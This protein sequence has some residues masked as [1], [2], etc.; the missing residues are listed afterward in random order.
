ARATADGV[1][2]GTWE[3][4]L[5]LHTGT[6]TR[7]VPVIEPSGEP[8]RLTVPVPLVRQVRRKAARLVRGR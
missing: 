4:Q 7:D 3:L 8:L 5:R 6:F 1:T 2:P